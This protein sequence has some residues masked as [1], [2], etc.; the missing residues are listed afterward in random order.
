MKKLCIGSY[1]K[2]LFSAKIA[3]NEE[4]LFKSLVG[5]L[6]DSE[7]DYDSDKSTIGKYKKGAAISG[8]LTIAASAGNVDSL[9][10]CYSEDLVKK[11]SPLKQQ[12]LILAIKDLLTSETTLHDTVPIGDDTQYTKYSILSSNTFSLSA[13]L[14]NVTMYCLKTPNEATPEIDNIYLNTFDLRRNEIHLDDNP[15]RVNT[16]LPFTARQDTFSKTFFEVTHPGAL[17]TPNQSTIKIYAL[18]FQNKEFSFRDIN[19]FINQNIG[20]Y[21]FSRA[22]R[23]DYKVK[24]DIE[25]LG[26]DSVKELRRINPTLSLGD[27]FSEIMLYSFLECALYAPKVLSKVELNKLSGTFNSSSS[28]VHLLPSSDLKIRNH[29]LAFGAS[30][31]YNDLT[32]AIGQA[33]LQVTDILKNIDDEIDLVESS[34]LDSIFDRD[35]TDFLKQTLMPSRSALSKPD[36]SFGVFLGYSIS[37]DGTYSLSNYDFSKFLRARMTTDILSA[38]PYI[39][40]QINTLGLT[41]HSFYFYVLP[42]IDADGDKNIIMNSSLGVI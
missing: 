42:L 41:G 34:V 14:A 33:F 18:Q 22:K 20:R 23:N 17:L 37:L 36:T 21:V 9:S 31:V 35:T 12:S 7:F 19:S 6:F 26:L 10:I 29:Q 2:I 39:Q 4:E 30:K 32:S 8:N 28:G 1:L 27:H 5:P 15:L 38:I 24:E 3:K 25:S 13:I 16:V 40:N 11:L